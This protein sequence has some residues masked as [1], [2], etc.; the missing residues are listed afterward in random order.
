M[1]S[2][3][4]I[5]LLVATAL[6]DQSAPPC[7]RM[8]EILGAVERL[9]MVTLGNYGGYAQI[10]H[11]VLV[12]LKDKT[13]NPAVRVLLQLAVLNGRR[14]C[15]DEDSLSIQHLFD[16]VGEEIDE[17]EKGPR[18]NRCLTFFLYQQQVFGARCGFYAQASRAAAAEAG[19]NTEPHTRA[20]SLYLSQVY[21]MYAAIVS[22][23]REDAHK[24]FATMDAELRHFQLDVADTALEIQWA[25]G[26][27]PIHLLQ[28]MTL[29]DITDGDTWDAYMN[30]VLSNE[31]ALGR[32]FA[33]SIEVLR[34]GDAYRHGRYDEVL[35]NASAIIDDDKQS[36][37]TKAWAR[38][39]LA[40]SYVLDGKSSAARLQYA[41]IQPV[42][43]AHMVAAVAARELSALSSS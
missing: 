9:V 2:A 4:L 6:V 20:I 33:P 42:P 32:A 27:G 29:M 21:A 34:L 14:R 13:V 43:D 23:V 7:W 26:N 16:K 40:R 12:C 38:L 41:L 25:R 22:G 10:C 3:T 1:D 28:A 8:N 11:G 30:V 36:L 18:R 5:Q 35:R 17:L 31:A 39:I 37:A 15:D 24:A 19:L